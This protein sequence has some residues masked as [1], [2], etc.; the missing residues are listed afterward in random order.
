[1]SGYLLDTHAAIWFFN[2]DEALSQTG[3]CVI[4]NVS[5]KIYLSMAS[6]WELTIKIS[7]GKLEFASKTAGFIRLAE[8]NKIILIPIKP[9][10]LIILEKLPHIHRDPLLWCNTEFPEA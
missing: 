7:L 1:M 4:R 2:G 9:A 10:H 5:N 3:N 6:V 8:E